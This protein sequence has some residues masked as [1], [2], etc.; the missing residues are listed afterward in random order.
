LL[1]KH[2]IIKI[3]KQIRLPSDTGAQIIDLSGVSKE[4]VRMT[5]VNVSAE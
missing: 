3:R 4:M 5:G 2:S 1:A